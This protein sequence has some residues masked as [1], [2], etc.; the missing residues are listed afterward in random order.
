MA[1]IALNSRK[2][3]RLAEGKSC[4]IST[5]QVE[6]RKCSV[7]KASF[8]NVPRTS[9]LLLAGLVSRVTAREEEEVQEQME[10]VTTVRKRLNMSEHE[11]SLPQ[12]SVGEVERAV[13]HFFGKWQ[14]FTN[15]TITAVEF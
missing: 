7:E 13:L 12:H 10:E 6:H 1:I 5:I 3:K 9:S 2:N 14:K 15:I 8:F 4:V 11:L